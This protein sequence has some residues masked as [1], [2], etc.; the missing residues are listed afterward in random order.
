MQTY[1]WLIHHVMARLC[2]ICVIFFFPSLLPITF[3]SKY[4]GAREVMRNQLHEI[5]GYLRQLNPRSD[6]YIGTP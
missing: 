4:V 1:L 2:F 6:K 3:I 5:V